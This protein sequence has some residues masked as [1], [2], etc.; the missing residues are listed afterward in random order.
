M[1]RHLARSVSHHA[2]SMG[3]AEAVQRSLAMVT[4]GSNAVCAIVAVDA[5]LGE[6]TTAHN[7]R[8][9]P[10]VVATGGGL[11]RMGETIDPTVPS[12]VL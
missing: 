10:V 7:G 3:L 1:N 11:H 4:E 2:Q 12:E 6:V 5:L 9:F 8:S